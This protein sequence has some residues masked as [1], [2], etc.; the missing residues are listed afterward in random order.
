VPTPISAPA[1]KIGWLTFSQADQL[2]PVVL[3]TETHGD[4][5][6]G[7]RRRVEDDPGEEGLLDLQVPLIA[8][9]RIDAGEQAAPSL[10]N[11]LL[12]CRQTQS[13]V[14]QVPVALEGQSD[15]LVQRV[16]AA[17]RTLR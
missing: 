8:D 17:L 12:S 1:S 15:R 11:L 3:G 5:L 6:I 13:G 7:R 9:R 16:G 4:Q 2:F 10:A 14:S